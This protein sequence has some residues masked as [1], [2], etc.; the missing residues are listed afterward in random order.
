MKY[1]IVCLCGSTKFKD[2]FIK[3]T[4]LLSLSGYVVLS[5]GLFGHADNKF[6]TVITDEV[7]ALLDDMH[8]Q[9]IEMADFIYIIN[10]NNYIGESTLKELE[11]AKSL[12]KPIKYMYE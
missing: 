3:A 2:D 12:S 10:K 4:E 6:G 1:P 5:V 7:K 11:Y 9:K 8:K